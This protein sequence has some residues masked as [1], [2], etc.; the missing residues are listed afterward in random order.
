MTKIVNRPAV[1]FVVAHPDDVA[2]VL[3]RNITLGRLA[4]C[5]YAEAYTTGLALM[6]TR[7]NRKTGSILMEL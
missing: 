6:A 3:A 5:D 4:W 7:W 1:V 2:R